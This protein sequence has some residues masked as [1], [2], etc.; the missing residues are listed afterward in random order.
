MRSSI[1]WGAALALLLLAA[2]APVAATT[3]LK[4]DLDDL[5]D[6]ADLIFRATVLAVEP[7][8]V[9]VGGGELPTV[10]YRLRVDEAFK[11]EFDAA[12]KDAPVVEVTVVGSLK[13]S[14]Y[15][16]GDSARF[17]A[18]PRAPRLERGGEY[19]LFTTAPSAIGLSTTVGLGQGA[20]KIFL[21][22]DRQEMAVNELGN[23][24]LFDGPVTYTD[25]AHAI[26][27]EVGG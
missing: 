11:G 10:T 24:G 22:A 9:A 17:S 6:R 5:A 13:D 23:L 2:A 3:V 4:M 12:G 27:A 18:L 14:P 8:T 20:F 25:L 16:Q 21:S 15:Q 26:R 1:G 7:G 19:L